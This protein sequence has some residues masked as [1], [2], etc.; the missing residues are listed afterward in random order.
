[1]HRTT[2]NNDFLNM[3]FQDKFP[4]KFESIP[5]R[6]FETMDRNEL[7]E[8][9]TSLIKELLQND[10]A[11]LCNIIY[12]HDVQEVKF[13]KALELPDIVLQAEK[14]S[15]LVIERELQKVE[16]RKAYRRYKENNNKK[17]L[18]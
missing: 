10:F 15:D 8:K 7:K 17:S 3:D 9:L 12:R 14:I 5:G 2:Q 6:I 18:K 1:M 13:Q 11:R 16:T 4:D